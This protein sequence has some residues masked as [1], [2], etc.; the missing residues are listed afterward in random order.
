MAC[1]TVLFHNIL[2]LTIVLQIHKYTACKELITS[3]YHFLLG[4]P[5]S[6]GKQGVQS[7]NFA[8]IIFSCIRVICPNYCNLIEL[9]KRTMVSCC[10]STASSKF[11]LI[12]HFP[13]ASSVGPKIFLKIPCSKSCSFTTT[14]CFNSQI[15]HTYVTIGLINV[16]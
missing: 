10:I 16:L 14:F 1:S 15:L 3:S 13:Q 2:A 11:I 4:L 8:D 7:V 5:L 9:M 6:C 12:L